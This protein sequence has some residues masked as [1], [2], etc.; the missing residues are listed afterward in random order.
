MNVRFGRKRNARTQSDGLMSGATL[1]FSENGDGG[2]HV[3][4]RTN[5]MS[6]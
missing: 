2:L 6:A 5:P 4:L 1:F 3:C